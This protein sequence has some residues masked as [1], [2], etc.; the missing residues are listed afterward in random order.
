MSAVRS[1][2]PI[3][4]LLSKLE[5]VKQHGRGHRAS[6]PSCGG[7]ASKLSVSEVETGAVLLHCFGGCTPGE[8]LGAIGLRLGDLF[9][10]RLRPETPAERRE[11]RERAQVA[12]WQ[13]A[14][15][16]LCKEVAVVYLAQRQLRN[17]LVL[18]EEDD[19]RLKL[20]EDRIANAR[21]MLCPPA[22]RFRPEVARR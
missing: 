2:R 16:M 17:W 6:C 18:S 14:L 20:A 19:A 22:A 7:S 21:N 10:E 8:V 13:A 5:R 12:G 15:E 9:P 3:D 11:A 1:V 4:L